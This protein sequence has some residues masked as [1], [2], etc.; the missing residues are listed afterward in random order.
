MKKIK[1]KPKVNSKATL[2]L[3]LTLSPGMTAEA[4]FVDFNVSSE[5]TVAFLAKKSVT[6]LN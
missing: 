3:I 2:D 4:L 5:M 6:F 1:T